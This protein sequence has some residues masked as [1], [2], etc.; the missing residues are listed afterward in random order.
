MRVIFRSERS[1]EPILARHPDVR[2]C[3]CHSVIRLV[4][5][6]RDDGTIGTSPDGMVRFTCP[7]CGRFNNAYVGRLDDGMFGREWWR[8]ENERV[9]SRL[10]G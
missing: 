6:D 1:R 10:A 3:G 8:P 9:L 2:C 7:V 5:S 4:P